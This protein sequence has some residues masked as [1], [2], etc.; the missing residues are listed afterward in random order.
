MLLLAASFGRLYFCQLLC[1]IRILFPVLMRRENGNDQIKMTK[2]TYKVR[3]LSWNV[4]L[5]FSTRSSVT[6]YWFRTWS[7]TIL[8]GY[9]FV[10]SVWEEL[11]SLFFRKIAKKEMMHISNFVRF[12]ITFSPSQR[13][14]LDY[15]VCGS[16][17]LI[18][19]AMALCWLQLHWITITFHWFITDTALCGQLLLGYSVSDIVLCSIEILVSKEIMEMCKSLKT[20]FKLTNESLW[21]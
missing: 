3:T 4:S 9:S 8:T 14:Q 12:M 18:T 6:R 10:L 17:T 11:F 13:T 7:L 19:H 5:P 1:Q 2:I 20:K 15:L 21:N 16:C